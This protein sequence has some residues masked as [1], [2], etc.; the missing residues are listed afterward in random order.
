MNETKKIKKKST[1]TPKKPLTHFWSMSVFHVRW[2]IGIN[3]FLFTSVALFCFS[4]SLRFRYTT[5]HGLF[6]M[7][8]GQ[9]QRW[10][11]YP[12]ARI[13]THTTHKRVRLASQHNSNKQMSTV[14]P[15]TRQLCRCVSALHSRRL[16]VTHTHTQHSTLSRLPYVLLYIYVRCIASCSHTGWSMKRS[17]SLPNSLAVYRIEYIK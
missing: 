12:C 11:R 2:P 1:E 13:N 16:L 4:I 10:R 17:H 6:S 15:T 9:R 5:E 8:V 3:F 14:I 7:V